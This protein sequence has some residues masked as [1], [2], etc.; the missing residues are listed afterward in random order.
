[1]FIKIYKVYLFSKMSF[2]CL[3]Q[4]YIHESIVHL[5]INSNNK[6]PIKFLNTIKKL[7][8]TK[9]IVFL[10]LDISLDISLERMLKRGDKL[11]KFYSLRKRRYEL[12]NKFHK[13]LLKENNHINNPK[14]NLSNL[15]INSE[16]SPKLNINEVKNWLSNLKVPN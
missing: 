2:I 1:M 11:K 3:N 16:S 8:K 15:T 14:I 6:K 9:N 12:A 13:K 7:Y 5:S 10:Y 4:I